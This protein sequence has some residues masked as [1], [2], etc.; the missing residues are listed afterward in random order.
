MKSSLVRGTII[1]D[2]IFFSVL[3]CEIGK[4]FIALNK[5]TSDYI[6]NLKS[7]EASPDVRILAKFSSTYR[8]LGEIVSQFNSIYCSGQIFWYSMYILYTLA[9]VNRVVANGAE[10]IGAITSMIGKLVALTLMLQSG[11]RYTSSIASEAKHFQYL[12]NQLSCCTRVGGVSVQYRVQNLDSYASREDSHKV[13]CWG[14]F[15]IKR[16]TVLQTISLL[17]YYLVVSLQMHSIQ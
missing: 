14:L 9:C 2:C 3:S 12:I 17:V 11:V 16:G 1:F 5:A 8:K 7:L 10:N 13:T 6:D 15:Y 4:R